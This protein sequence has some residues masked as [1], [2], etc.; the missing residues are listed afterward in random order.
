[1][2]KVYSEC[3]KNC[4][5]SKDRIVSPQKA[6]EIVKGCLE[7]QDYFICHKS[8]IEG[9]DTGEGGDIMCKSFHDQFAEHSQLYRIAQRLNVVEFVPQTDTPR[10]PSYNEMYNDKTNKTLD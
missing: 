6:K 5:L 8:S 10:L 7:T 3:C 2:M 9:L 1:M 4:L